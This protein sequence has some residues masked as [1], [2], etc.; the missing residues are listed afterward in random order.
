MKNDIIII[1]AGPAGLTAG[2]YT[3]RNRY[4]TLII[5]KDL[6]GQTA[7]SGEIA[8][9]PGIKEITGVELSQKMREHF[10]SYPDGELKLG[11]E[12]IEISGEFP[13]FK[14]KAKS[15]DEYQSK[16]VIITAGKDPKRLNVPGEKEFEGKGVSYC[17]TC[18]APFF[19][20]KT[21]AIIGGG[22]SATEGA[23]MLDKYAAKTFVLSINRELKGE[24]ITLEKIKA[25]KKITLIGNAQTEEILANEKVKGVKYKDKTS[26]QAKELGVDG[27]FVEIGSVPNTSY[28]KNQIK[29]NQWQE[30]EID[31][32]NMTNIPGI[33]AAGDITSVFGKQ[34][35]I[36]AGEGAKAAIA[37][38]ELILTTKG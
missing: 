24:K 13:Q 10:L 37:A 34:T 21:V 6:G 2:I 17:A 1:G 3:V 29:L 12:I 9:Y 16:V 26:G 20:D 27:V 5:S 36:A 15:G 38:N 23:A 8:N 30:I 33:F 35:V 28:F 11:E 31:E 18:D 32:K 25:S 7:I 4:K 19:K 14:V 22:Y